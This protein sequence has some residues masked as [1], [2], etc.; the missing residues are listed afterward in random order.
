MLLSSSIV[1]YVK[2][3]GG[4]AIEEQTIPT[5]RRL[6]SNKQ[7]SPAIIFSRERMQDPRASLCVMEL[8]QAF[9]LL[10]SGFT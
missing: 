10:I 1:C 4:A 7:T 2:M 6:L 3:C 9:F 5:T 8:F